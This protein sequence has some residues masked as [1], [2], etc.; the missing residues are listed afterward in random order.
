MCDECKRLRQV[1]ETRADILDHW[2]HLI[3][4]PAWL[5]RVIRGAAEM[6]R[7]EAE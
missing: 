5:P 4:R 2:A 7:R 1:I 3:K 6:L